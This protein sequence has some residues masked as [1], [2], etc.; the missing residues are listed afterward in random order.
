MAYQLSDLRT[1]I[2][3]KLDDT[4]FST[5]LLT[6]FINDTQRDIFNS[7]DF[8]FNQGFDASKT[9]VQGEYSFTVPTDLQRIRVLT[10]SS[11][12]NEELDLTRYFMNFTT[13]KQ[14][15][16]DQD[17]ESQGIPTWWT[18]YGNNVEFAYQADKTYTFKIYYTKIPTT[19]V[20]NTDVPEVP[21]EF[22]ELLVM[23]GY[24]R[25]LEH[26][27]DNDIADYHRT[28]YYVPQLQQ[29]VNRYSPRVFGKQTR[30][31]NSPWRI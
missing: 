17:D 24:I 16:F 22:E 2:Q 14:H 26:N 27:D 8:P 9:V 29:L 30:M 23:G 10:I 20:D 4:N 3:A 6:D 12:E 31:R 13:F 19:L 15:F 1:R 11:P 18:I 25:A 5:T 21:P 28:R 7:Y